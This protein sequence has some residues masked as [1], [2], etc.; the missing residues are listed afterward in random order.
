MKYLPKIPIEIIS[1]VTSEAKA[2]H[3]QWLN[4]IDRVLIAKNKE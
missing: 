3:T 1:E 2:R 4:D